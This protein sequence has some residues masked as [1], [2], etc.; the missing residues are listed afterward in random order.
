MTTNSRSGIRRRRSPYPATTA[1]S[2]GA[3]VAAISVAITSH[4]TKSSSIAPPPQPQGEHPP[5]WP[6]WTQCMSYGPD[7]LCVEPSHLF[8]PHEL[9]SRAQS[10]ASAIGDIPCPCARAGVRNS[11]LVSSRVFRVIVRTSDEGEVDNPHSIHPSA[12]CRPLTGVSQA[13]SAPR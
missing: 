9:H 6:V 13:T 4:E 2:R 3:G 1:A 7:E 12:G 8:R 11:R 5:P 10:L